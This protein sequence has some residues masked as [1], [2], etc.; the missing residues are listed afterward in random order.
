MSTTNGLGIVKCFREP[1][2]N[3]SI[4]IV[5]GDAMIS[6]EQIRIEFLTFL[7]LKGAT[8]RFSDELNRRKK[9]NYIRICSGDRCKVLVIINTL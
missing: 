4:L 9:H 1:R 7:G 6:V 8:Q 3:K 5:Y 2:Q